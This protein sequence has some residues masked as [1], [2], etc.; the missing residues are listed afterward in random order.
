MLE[1]DAFFVSYE[2]DTLMKVMSGADVLQTS[3]KVSTFGSK[4]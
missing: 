3:L 1:K 4:W 2:N